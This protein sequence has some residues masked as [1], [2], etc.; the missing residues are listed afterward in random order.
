MRRRLWRW[1]CRRRDF[2]VSARAPA[3]RGLVSL[4]RAAVGGPGKCRGAVLRKAGGVAGSLPGGHHL[5]RLGRDKGKVSAGCAGG[6]ASCVAMLP[7]QSVEGGA[8]QRHR[9]PG[10]QRWLQYRVDLRREL[11]RRHHR[12]IGGRAHSR[13]TAPP[14]EPPTARGHR[15]RR[16]TAAARVQGGHTG[17]GQLLPRG[18]QRRRLDVARDGCGGSLPGTRP[19]RRR[20]LFRA[21]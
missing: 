20:G 2:G 8:P 17:G 13:G 6:L 21:G 10:C 1:R 16:A 3:R 4:R 7:K 5:P 15:P 14:G 9:R 19:L 12:R 11:W 18:L